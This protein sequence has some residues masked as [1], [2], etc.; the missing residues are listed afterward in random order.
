MALVGCS[1]WRL[2]VSSTW[3]RLMKD[4]GDYEAM[5]ELFLA[6]SS[7]AMELL[8]EVVHDSNTDEL[9][10]WDDKDNPTSLTFYATWY[11]SWFF[12]FSHVLTVCFIEN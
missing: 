11:F 10:I 9:A 5:A 2:R 6:D 3:V 7:Y 4:R 8:I 12:R 1:F